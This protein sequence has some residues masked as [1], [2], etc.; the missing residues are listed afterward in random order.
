MLRAPYGV[1]RTIREAGEL[2]ESAMREA[3]SIANEAGVNLNEQDVDDWYRVLS[4]LAL[5]GKT[6]ML[7]D[8]EAK[9]KT[10]VEMFAG[11]VIELGRKYGIPAPVN[12]TIYRAIKVMERYL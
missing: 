11:K 12:L 9:R 2:M 5:Q 3:M 4:G 10:E 8:I 7:Q 1:F 6:S